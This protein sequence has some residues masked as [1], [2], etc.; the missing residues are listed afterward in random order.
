MYRPLRRK[1]GVDPDVVVL[2]VQELLFPMEVY[3]I[4]HEKRLQHSLAEICA[5]RDELV[6]LLKAHD[7]HYLRMAIEAANMVTCGEL[8]LRA[9]LTRKESRG[10]HLRED[11]GAIDNESWL[12]W[13]ILRQ[14]ERGDIGVTTEEIPT[15]RYPVKPERKSTTHPIAEAMD[16]K[17]NHGHSI[18]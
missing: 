1:D 13:I 11:Y 2:S 17:W 12:K 18:D 16:D 5:L 3:I 9:A 10:S 15:D 14:G 4:R 8:F 7:P 6:P